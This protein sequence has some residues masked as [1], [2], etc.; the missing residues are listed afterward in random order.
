MFLDDENLHALTGIKRRK[1]QIQW[2]QDNGIPFLVAYSG[3][4]VV[5]IKY[6]EN[7]L[8][9]EEKATSQSANPNFDLLN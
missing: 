6:I 2:L 9:P 8:L 4:P 3:R 7:I 1:M 5:L